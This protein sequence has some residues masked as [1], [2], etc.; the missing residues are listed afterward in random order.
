MI[1]T[2]LKFLTRTTGQEQIPSAPCAESTPNPP[3][4]PSTTVMQVVA[5]ETIMAV[6]QWLVNLVNHTM[7]AKS[8]APTEPMPEPVEKPPTE[9]QPTMTEELLTKF[10]QLIEQLSDREQKI[11]PLEQRLQQVETAFAKEDEVARQLRDTMQ[12]IDRLS[13]RLIRV[14]DLAGRVNVYEIDGLSEQNEQFNQRLSESNDAIALVDLRLLQ[15]ESQLHQQDALGD[16]MI[17]LLEH[18]AILRHRVDRL[19]KW[20]TQLMVIPQGHSTQANGS[21]TGDHSIEQ[22]SHLK[23]FHPD[24]ES[25]ERS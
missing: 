24:Q 23:H 19:E 21:S 20:L 12:Y 15:L 14:E 18:M 7:Q 5:E 4:P 3:Q 16:R 6:A 13:Q 22:N 25:K 8:V 1:M 2:W 17:Q 11:V 9:T 10:G